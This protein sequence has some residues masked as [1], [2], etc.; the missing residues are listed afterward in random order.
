MDV[1]LAYLVIQHNWLN[2]HVSNITL[3]DAVTEFQFWF[4]IILGF[5]TYVVWGLIFN[6][7]M[8]TYEKSNKVKIYV[9]NKQ[10]IITRNEGKV[11]QLIQDN[12]SIELAI[13]DFDSKISSERN[14]LQNPQFN[15]ANY[16]TWHSQYI[17]GWING[18]N[19]LANVNAITP[20]RQDELSRQTIDTSK[21]FLVNNN[22]NNLN[23]NL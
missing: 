10:E 17:S 3:I 13:S 7:V 11:K 20:Q 12:N 22:L 14:R 19:H 9:K 2:T 18:I 6:W 5:V 23:N 16:H 21:A 1:I 15:F 8:N 4:I